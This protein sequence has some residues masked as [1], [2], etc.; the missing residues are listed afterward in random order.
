MKSIVV[1]VSI[2]I[3][4]YTIGGDINNGEIYLQTTW[5]CDKLQCDNTCYNC[6]LENRVRTE[7]F[8]NKYELIIKDCLKDLF[9]K[10]NK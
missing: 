9:L 3:D 4:D 5:N 6:P 2:S 1:R 8:K 10:I 7:E